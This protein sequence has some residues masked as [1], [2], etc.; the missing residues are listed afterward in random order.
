MASLND[1]IDQ[2]TAVLVAEE[3]G[4]QV[5]FEEEQKLSEEQLSYPQVELSFS[6]QESQ[7][8]RHPVVTVMGPSL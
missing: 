5:K 4:F 8:K 6:D 7:T 1:E 2:E 3:F